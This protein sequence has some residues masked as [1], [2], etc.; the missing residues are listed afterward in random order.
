MRQL[1]LLRGCHLP[2]LLRYGWLCDHLPALPAASP[3]RSSRG[4]KGYDDN[5]LL[6]A[7]VVRC[8]ATL[9]T[10][11]ALVDALNVNPSLVDSLGMNPL[12]GSPP[13]E[14]FSSFLRDTPNASLQ[15]VRLA[16]VQA[17]IQEGVIGGT[18]LAIDSCPVIA[19]VRENNLKTQLLRARFDKTQFPRGDREARLGVRIHYPRQKQRKVTY[20]WGYRHHTIS[21]VDSE[22][23]VCEQTHPANTSEV[24]IAIPLLRSAQALNLATRYV[25]GDSAYDAEAVLAVIVNELQ[26]QPVVPRRAYQTEGYTIREG[27]VYCAADLPMV[28]KGKMTAHRGYTYRQYVCPLH[29][30]KS[31]QQKFLACPAFHPKYFDQKGCNV[32]IRLDPSVRSQIPYGTEEFQNLYHKRTAV[33]RS[34]ARLLTL[35][36]EH[37]TVRGLNSCRNHCTI[38]HIA[39]LL[40]ALAASRLGEPDKIRAIRTFVPSL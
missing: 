5:L 31:L 4:R 25:A 37:P 21:D 8:L 12:Q 19:P 16:L 23:P 38:A 28:H 11:A 1:P 18:G 22:L 10:L 6:R 36:L 40:V 34:Y 13:V 9:P 14:R 32:L 20:F 2:P 26:A 15:A 24:K 27:R 33:E 35:T 29:W 3:S 30:R 39:T 7:L 17:L